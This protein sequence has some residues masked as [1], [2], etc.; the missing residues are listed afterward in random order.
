VYTYTSRRERERV[1]REIVGA[2][3]AKR[4]VLLGALVVAGVVLGVLGL[5]AWVWWG[6][7]REWAGDWGFFSHLV[8]G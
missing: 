5:L 4:R 8:G 7:V 6:R 1:K 3:R 2:W